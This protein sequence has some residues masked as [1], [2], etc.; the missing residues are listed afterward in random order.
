MWS[1]LPNEEAELKAGTLIAILLLV[2]VLVHPVVHV[3]LSAG[4]STPQVRQLPEQGNPQAR[5]ENPGTCLGCRTADSLVAAPLTIEF[6]G[7]SR[8]QEA[9]PFQPV[10][11]RF[12]DFNPAVSSRAPPLA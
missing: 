12:Q 7:V 10:S 1:C 8:S 3:P 5:L 11:Y 2:Q 6:P 4:P 9:V